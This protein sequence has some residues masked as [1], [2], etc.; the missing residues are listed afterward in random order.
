MNKKIIQGCH[1]T[2][3]GITALLQRS[4]TILPSVSITSTTR[5]RS[6]GS[7]QAIGAQ[8]RECLRARL[9]R[10]SQERGVRGWVD[11]CECLLMQEQSGQMVKQYEL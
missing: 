2:I 5:V 1:L 8:R 9:T 3:I 11:P 4:Q 7:S 10:P 6:T